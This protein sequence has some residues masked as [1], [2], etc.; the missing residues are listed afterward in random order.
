MIVKSLIL[1]VMDLQ[2]QLLFQSALTENKTVFI[3]QVIQQPLQ[4]SWGLRP[5]NYIYWSPLCEEISNLMQTCLV[6]ALKLGHVKS[7]SPSLYF[8]LTA[9]WHEIIL[10][11][12]KKI[13]TF[14]NVDSTLTTLESLYIFPGLTQG[15]GE[16]RAEYLNWASFFFSCLVCWAF[17]YSLLLSMFTQK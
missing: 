10:P 14:V 3:L 5:N 2:W 7:F 6:L 9:V 8:F 4:N 1:T 12:I 13:F 15:F 16:W 11:T 17:A